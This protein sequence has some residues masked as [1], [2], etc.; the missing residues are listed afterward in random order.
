MPD[1]K[2]QVPM[3]ALKSAESQALFWKKQAEALSGL[4]T[5]AMRDGQLG[6]SY[7]RQAQRLIAG[8]I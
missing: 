7:V 8:V 6:T 5:K 4:L 2:R 3:R 1:T